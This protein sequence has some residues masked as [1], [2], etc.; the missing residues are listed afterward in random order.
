MGWTVI[1]ESFGGPAQDLNPSLR[2]PAG[3]LILRH[4]RILRIISKAAIHDLLAF[5][6]SKQGK[7]HESS[8]KL[9][10]TRLLSDS[11]MAE[12]LQD[13]E[14]S[15][16]AR[17]IE[18]GGI[19]EHERI[20]FPSYPYEWPP[21]MLQ[22][23]GQLTL[24]LATGLLRE[25]LGVKDATP[26][27]ILFR[28][29]SPVFVD[30][31]SVERRE[32]RDPIWLACAQFV[33]TFLLPL[34]VNREFGVP[35]AQSLLSR[36]DGL[37]PEEVYRLCSAFQK[38]RPPFLSLVSIPAWLEGRHR[39]E[40]QSIYRP[41]LVK[42][43]QQARYVLGAL[44]NRLRRRL[45]RLVPANNRESP[46]ADYMESHCSYSPEDFLAK[47]AFVEKAV[48]ECQP[49]S[50]LDIGC[51][52]GHFSALA[53]GRGAGVVAIDSD[54]VVVGEVWRM[55]TREKLDILPLVI[56]I[57]RPSPSMG[58]RNRECLS[59]LD[60][61]S[62]SFDAV[63]MLALVHHLLV[64]ERIPLAEIAELA[65]M[66]TSQLLIIEYV[67]PED[68][69]FRCLTR[70]RDSLFQGLNR[71]VFEAA[72]SPHFECLESHRFEQSKRWLYLL[73]K[74]AGNDTP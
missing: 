64:S 70:G 56:N 31:L 9:V 8:G 23:A 35:L 38:L 20:P 25:G 55:A 63:F 30:V 27:N 29:S 61:A 32:P 73:R 10:R 50:V 72:F 66:L 37:E 6:A 36:R 71:Q 7:E 45:R 68:A 52:T 58:W 34:L 15:K 42:D 22:A 1:E 11:E 47:Q 49:R 46:W 39:P 53:A 69:M 4:S 28:G 41:H 43:P 5:L 48:S 24:E 44:L 33:R 74:R 26:Y 59:F 60:R 21:E 67:G 18:V 40:D 12:I 17:G 54:P 16:Q 65:S 19:A 13:P 3:T 62:G 57:A 51:N 14:V 2:D